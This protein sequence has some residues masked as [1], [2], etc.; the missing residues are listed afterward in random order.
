MGKRSS[1]SIIIWLGPDWR[2]NHYL[3]QQMGYE[4]SKHLPV[5]YVNSPPIIPNSLS[6]SKLITF[7]YETLSWLKCPE[8]VSES[9]YIFTPFPMLPYGHLRFIDECYRIICSYTVSL[10]AKKLG[11]VN[12]LLW[13]Y[14]PFISPYW[15]KLDVSFVCYDCIDKH[16]SMTRFKRK[17]KWFI[18][19]ERRF[20][21]LA[22]LVIATSRMLCGE[23]AR[24]GK[25]VY[26][27]PPGADVKHYLRATY[28]DTPTPEDISKISHPIIGYIGTMGN[29][30][31]D[32]ELIRY[33]SS[34]RPTW[35][36]V[37]VGPL[38]E[39]PD[40]DLSSL[41]NIY[42]LGRKCLEDLPGYLKAFDVSTIPF[43]L[44]EFASYAFPTKTFEYLA[45]GK[46]VVSTDL[47]ALREYHP[48][49]KVAKSKEEFLDRIQESLAEEGS[50]IVSRRIALA[51]EHTWGE[52]A[53]R[54]LQLIDITRTN[55][56]K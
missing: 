54:A 21:R 22:D 6:S 4:L 43:R 13:V 7:A 36:F 17:R 23:K 33:L 8:K 29:T 25:N 41:K 51:H 1:D 37:F 39:Q 3:P 10:A 44:N 32:W 38:V 19:Q 5:L 18:E 11:F 50:A 26:F 14:K 45:S 52:R 53:K 15:K 42:F 2:A 56:G 30:K 55:L 48:L 28:S 31:M 16:S 47:S 9:L 27:V 40:V 24:I 34:S 12:P 35:S 49:V 20:V 46:P